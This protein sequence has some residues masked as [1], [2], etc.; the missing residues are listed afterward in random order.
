[1][2]FISRTFPY[3]RSKVTKVPDAT[4]Q[5]LRRSKMVSFSGNSVGFRLESLRES[6]LNLDI[7]LIYSRT[8]FLGILLQV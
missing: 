3:E 2:S 1:M 7:V 5:Q 4:W 8:L 6:R